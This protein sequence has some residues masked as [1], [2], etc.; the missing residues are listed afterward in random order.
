M[1]LLCFNCRRPSDTPE[2]THCHFVVS[3]DLIIVNNF[4]NTPHTKNFMLC[5][6][7]IITTLKFKK[8]IERNF[9]QY[10]FTFCTCGIVTCLGWFV[11]SF[12]L[13]CV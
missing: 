10:V 13:S 5:N 3:L 9:T 6:S 2:K 4:V 1:F 8:P 12:K 7:T 11:A